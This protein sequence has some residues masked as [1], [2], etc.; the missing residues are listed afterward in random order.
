MI[1]FIKRVGFLRWLNKEEARPSIRVPQAGWRNFGQANRNNKQ[2]EDFISE[3]D[4]S[5][6]NKKF[7]SVIFPQKDLRST[8][9]D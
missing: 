3:L 4:T 5:I 7:I 9:I 6:S 2:F 8:K 1:R